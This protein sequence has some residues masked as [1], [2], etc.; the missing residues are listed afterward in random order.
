VERP[1]GAKNREFSSTLKT[2]PR[3]R[4]IL[5]RTIISSATSQ[6]QSRCRVL[7]QRPGGSGVVVLNGNTASFFGSD[8]RVGTGQITY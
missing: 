2:T 3:R 4:P 5:A 8:G 6:R 1:F 7:T